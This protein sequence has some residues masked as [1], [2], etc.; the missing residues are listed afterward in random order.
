M[1]APMPAASSLT[2]TDFDSR[3]VLHLFNGMVFKRSGPRAAA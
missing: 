1:I 3:P 2:G